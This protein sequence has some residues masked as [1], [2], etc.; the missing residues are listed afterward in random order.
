MKRIFFDVSKTLAKSFSID[1]RLISNSNRAKY[2]MEIIGEE[3][4]DIIVS[5]RYIYIYILRRSFVELAP[6]L[7]R[8][9][10]VV[11]LIVR[12]YYIL[13]NARTIGTLF[14]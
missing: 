9:R 5:I 13:Y 8:K 3:K 6:R 7:E 4:F 1:I 11:P 12:V 2:D 14:F 10:I